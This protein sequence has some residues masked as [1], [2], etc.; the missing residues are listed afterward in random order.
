LVRDVAVAANEAKTFEDALSNTLAR[1]CRFN[2]WCF[3]HAFLAT[4]EQ[5]DE[6]RPCRADYQEAPERFEQFRAFTLK[7]TLRRGQGLPGRVLASGRPEWTD[8]L[9]ED[10]VARRAEL[11]SDLGVK[12]ALAFPAIA[13]NRVVAVLEAFSDVGTDVPPRTL[14]MMNVVGLQLGLAAERSQ[15]AKAMH[16]STERLRAIL[17]TAADGILTIDASGAIQSL[18]A[19]AERIFGYSTA[20]VRRRNVEILMPSPSDRGLH[21]YLERFSDTCADDCLDRR[22]EAVGHR[23]D[24]TAFPIDLAVS[25]IGYLGLYV[26]IVRDLTAR[27]LAEREARRRQEELNH[28][29]RVAMMGELAAG[30][31][32]ELN[33]PLT[34]LVTNAQAAKRLLDSH[35][36]DRQKLRTAMDEIASSGKRAGELIERLR[37]FLRK[38]TREHRP[39]QVNDII[40]AIKD[41]VR[42]DALEHDATVRLDLADKLPFVPGDPIQLQQVLLN[43]VHNGL[44]AMLDH[45][46][47]SRELTV[48]TTVDER[49]RVMIL[50]RD[51]GVGVSKHVEHHLFKPFFTTKLSGMGMGLAIARS[52]VD[53]HSGRIW[54]T[55]NADRPDAGTTFH[56]A[57]P[58]AEE[59]SKR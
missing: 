22:T 26:C 18:N 42:V 3:G 51:T 15:A 13:D 31:A 45:E 19:A 44:Q 10:L 49:G 28:V 1:V 36:L 23:K 54:A 40:H 30:L 24:G 37:A 21:G 34:A 57:L 50:V 46:P 39:L 14:E 6:L 53:V 7:T 4:G 32:H 47:D 25:Q 33:Q 52:I 43:L 20:E 8:E 2:G 56:V 58:P 9:R 48:R 38:D 41:V 11:G 17:D 27:K 5:P 55:P 16:E 35:R 59:S 12:L 29:A